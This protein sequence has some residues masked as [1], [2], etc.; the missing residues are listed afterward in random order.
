MDKLRLGIKA[1]DELQPDLRELIDVMNRLSILPSDSEAKSKI[2]K[3][4][5]LLKILYRNLFNFF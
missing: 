4:Y 5:I 1:N 2:Q 3:W